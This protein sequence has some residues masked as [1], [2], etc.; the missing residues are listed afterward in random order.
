MR[1]TGGRRGGSTGAG[2]RARVRKHILLV[3]KKHAEQRAT[4]VHALVERETQRILPVHVTHVEL[5]LL[6]RVAP[7]LTHQHRVRHQAIVEG[8]RRGCHSYT[9]LITILH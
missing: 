1:G 5:L 3:E 7:A 4:A 6:E 2:E 9:A 8:L